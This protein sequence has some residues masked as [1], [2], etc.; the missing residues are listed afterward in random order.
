YFSATLDDIAAAL[1][2][3]LRAVAAV[4]QSLIQSENIV[5]GYPLTL[6]VPHSIEILLTRSKTQYLTNARLTQYETVILGAPNVTIKR[7]TVLNLA[8]LLPNEGDDPN[9][10]DDIEHDCLEVTELGTKPRDDIKDFCL[11]DN[12]QII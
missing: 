10:I 12:D 4:E 7:Y 6:M 2:G 9:R 1:P 3:Y 8:T 11:E 5:I